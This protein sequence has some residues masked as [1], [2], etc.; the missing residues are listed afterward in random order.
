MWS[1]NRRTFLVSPLAL[2]ACG[3]TPVYG[4]QGGGTALQNAVTLPEPANQASY[5]FNRRF[6]E[7]LGRAGAGAP[8][9][10]DLR[11]QT[12]EQDMGSTS[13][14]STTRYRLVGRVF[15]SLVDTA[16]GQ[17]LFE[18]RTNAFT[19]YSTTGSTVATR[20]AENDARGRLMVLLAD[21]VIDGLLL[22]G[23]TA[24]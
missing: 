15:Y 17:T 9:S 5:A 13:A 6:E 21:Q 2:A 10:L 18:S 11:I 20:A 12:D 14:G 19:G 23:V 1:C 16:T 4:P 3:F 8:Y 22:S 24:P 7:R